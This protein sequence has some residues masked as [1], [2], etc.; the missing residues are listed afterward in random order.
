MRDY[1]RLAD[2]AP[3]RMRKDRCDRVGEEGDGEPDE[4]PLGGAVGA[5]HDHQPNAKRGD[6]HRQLRGYSR[7]PEGCAG[8]DEVRDADAQVGDQHGGGGEHRP[9][10]PVLL[11]HELGEALAGDDAHTRC[12][13]LHDRQRDRDQDDRPQQAVAGFGSGFGVRGD[14]AG[15]EQPQKRENAGA[16][17]TKARRQTRS[18]KGGR[19]DPTHDGRYSDRHRTLR[20]QRSRR[21]VYSVLAEEPEAPA[22]A[23]R[24]HRLEHIVDR[25][26]AQHLLV[27]VDDWDR[28]EVVV[29]HQPRDLLEGR[30][31]GE[32]GD[33][34]LDLRVQSAAARHAQQ[35][36]HGDAARERGVRGSHEHGGQQLRRDRAAPNCLQRIS[37]GRGGV[38]QH[39]VRAH[40]PA[41]LGRVIAEQRAHLH[42]MADGQQS[43]DR[44]APVLLEL[45]DDVGC[46]VRRH[47]REDRCDLRVRAVLEE[48]PL[49]LVVELLEHVGLELAIIVADRLDD[50][51][52]LASRCRLHEIG[53]LGG[54]ELGQL[55]VRHSQAHRR[56][57]PHER[58]HAGPVD[59]S[60]ERDVGARRLG[61]QAAKA[62]ARARVDA[63]H[64]PGSGEQ[65]ELDLVRAH[66]SRALDVDQLP[67][68]QVAFEEHL[69]WTALEVAQVELG[70]AQ[71][72]AGGSDV[73][74]PVDAHE[75]GPPGHGHQH[76]R[77]R[78]VADAAQAHDQ[79][80]DLAQLLSVGVAQWAADDRGEVEDRRH[81]RGGRVH[82]GHRTPIFGALGTGTAA[83]SRS[84]SRP[85]A[86]PRPARR[87]PAPRRR[88]RSMLVAVLPF[89]ISI[90]ALS[91]VQ[92]ALVAVPGSLPAS[93]LSRPRGLG[94]AVI[95][96]LSVIAFVL[97]ARTAE[98]ASAQGLTYLALGAVPLLAALA[99]GWL[100]WDA[101]PPRP[102]RALLA[103]VLF[104]LAWI[105]R[106]GLVGE[107][108]AL[109]LTALSCVALGVLLAAV[110]PAR[111]LGAGIVA[112]AV[113][114]TTLVVSDLLQRPNDALNAARPAAG[115]P[116]LQSEVFGSAVMGYGD[117]FIAAALGGL[118]AAAA[119]RPLQLRTARLTALLALGFDL[120]FFLVDELPATV[121]VALALIAVTVSRR[122]RSARRGRARAG[123]PLASARAR[124][125]RVPSA[126]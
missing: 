87:L 7:Q 119:T 99:L 55:G 67:V 49:V 88:V 101:H 21:P 79:I 74:D 56:D 65:R 41:R 14:Q 112:M 69:L 125:A 66:Q 54:V 35:R 62:A 20:L 50:L 114:D 8:A 18:A 59:E 16:A 86:S 25:D 64:A 95:P 24:K 98:H 96:P 15:A 27:L 92:G 113:A 94:W 19:P 78:W 61:Q 107:A 42:S 43:Q 57:V 106:G 38:Q 23:A 75:R 44:L 12:Q 110:T 10:D 85:L 115:L 102:R 22:P 4:D 105:D 31:G 121:P 120:L 11:A 72:H 48:L 82:A 26:D 13:L 68:E 77:D 37:G 118:L 33:L 63:H 60:S 58:L 122:R 71:H 46:V 81:L 91:L 97:I 5:A 116:R 47:P 93:P 126:R 76:A 29:G 32:T 52:A 89:W 73:G 83:A 17:R 6:R 109:I 28:R 3:V 84:T 51:L 80:L 117:L 45:A 2:R 124:S 40:Q 53:D 36:G 104:G 30:V 39:E 90:A 34:V 108:A 70:L 111:W 100:L 103:V 123:S 9:A 1:D